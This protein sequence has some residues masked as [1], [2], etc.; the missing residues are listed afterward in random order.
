[1]SKDNGVEELIRLVKAG[2]D[3]AFTRLLRQY[4]VLIES[5]ANRYASLGKEYGDLADDFRQEA[6]MAMYRAAL[7]YDLD[8]SAVTF[9]L[10]AKTCIR[11]ALVSELRRLAAEPRKKAAQEEAAKKA[12][13]A[14]SVV[15]TEE[16]RRRFLRISEDILSPLEQQAMI[17]SFEGLKP[18]AAAKELGTSARA[19]TNALYRARTK[20]K[21][22]PDLFS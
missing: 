14:E 5:S 17:L 21:A 13:S 3:D 9:G 20:L 2:N 19:V 8:Q 1:M 12:E 11:N 6:A 22:Y 18:A 15:L 10:Y 4:S 7:R 16:M